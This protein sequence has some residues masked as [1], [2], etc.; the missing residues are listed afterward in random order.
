MQRLFAGG[1]STRHGLPPEK[2]D[3]RQLRNHGRALEQVHV[4]AILLPH[5]EL[6][7]DIANGAVDRACE[8][9]GLG[10]LQMLCLVGNGQ[11]N[12]ATG[13]FVRAKKVDAEQLHH[14][15]RDQPVRDVRGIEPERLYLFPDHVGEVVRLDEAGHWM[16]LD[17]LV[18]PAR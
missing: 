2:I 8:E 16:E 13:E 17:M 15:L 5:I 4:C 10:V 14:C 11:R 18:G 3:L 12:E 9:L 6:K 7:A 1:R